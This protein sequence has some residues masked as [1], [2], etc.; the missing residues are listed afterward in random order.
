MDEM[1]KGWPASMGSVSTCDYMPEALLLGLGLRAYA[2][3]H[4]EA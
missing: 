3:Q 1:D 2:E 4:L